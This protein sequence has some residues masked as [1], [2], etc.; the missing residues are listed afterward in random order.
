MAGLVPPAGRVPTVRSVL[1]MA[2]LMLTM[3][4]VPVGVGPKANLVLTVGRVPTSGTG[5]VVRLAQSR[6]TVPVC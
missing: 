5:P 4:I 3:A 6:S 1:T 2:R